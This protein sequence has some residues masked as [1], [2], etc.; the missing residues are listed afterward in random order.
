MNQSLSNDLVKKI[1]QGIDTLVTMT[2][3]PIKVRLQDLLFYFEL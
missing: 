2:I 3:K 1:M